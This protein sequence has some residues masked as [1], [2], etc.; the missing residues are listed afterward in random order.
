M[1]AV[2]SEDVV[3]ALAESVLVFCNS[4]DPESC[5]VVEDCVEAESPLGTSEMDEAG[6]VVLLGESPGA[7]AVLGTTIDSWKSDP[8]LT[9][10]TSPARAVTTVVRV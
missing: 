7:G 1:G 4:V 8:T 9:H 5:A 6:E 10:P 2:G 3:E